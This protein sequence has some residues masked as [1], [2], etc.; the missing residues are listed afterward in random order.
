MN[1]LDLN[2]DVLSMIG[3]YVKK[4]NE[5]RLKEERLIQ[6]LLNQY[7][8]RFE[9]MLDSY[10]RFKEPVDIYLEITKILV[11]LEIYLERDRDMEKEKIDKYL[12]L[13]IDMYKM[14]IDKTTKKFRR[15]ILGFRTHNEKL[16]YDY[17]YHRNKLLSDDTDTDEY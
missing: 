6:S 15:N 13:F 4:D 3:G 17:N 14:E 12:I 5:N 16:N 9:D 10:K 2:N 8:Y 1:L 7:R 11:D